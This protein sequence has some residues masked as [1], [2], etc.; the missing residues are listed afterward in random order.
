MMGSSL[1]PRK[2]CLVGEYGDHQE[3]QSRYSYLRTG[4]LPT[5]MEGLRLVDTQSPTL[6]SLP[7]VTIAAE[8]SRTLVLKYNA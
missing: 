8:K 5:K 1:L 4:V 3:W 2:Q 7:P 6:N